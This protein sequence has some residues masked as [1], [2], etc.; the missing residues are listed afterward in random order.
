MSQFIVWFTGLSGSGK[1]TISEKLFKDFKKKIKIKIIDGD[2]FRR[3]INN[4]NYNDFHREKLGHL[5]IKQAI[6]YYDK[7]Y[8]VIVSGVAYKRK[9]RSD[10]RK[11]CKQRI[12]REVFLKCSISQCIKRNI[13]KKKNK[14]LYKKEKYKYEEYKHYD[15]R[16]NTS[17]LDPDTMYIKLKKFIN[18]IHEQ[19]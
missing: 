18:K 13:K 14:D 12:Y 5:K 17:C 11:F 9:W 10:L 3:K 1:T 8:S 6:K 15:L 4:Y 19:K 16:L 2:I 7:G